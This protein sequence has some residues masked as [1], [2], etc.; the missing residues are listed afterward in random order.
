MTDPATTEITGAT[1][2]NPWDPD[3]DYTY[4]ASDRRHVWNLSMVA[5]MPAWSG[6]AGAIFGDWQIAPIIR[7][8]SGNRSHVT[9]GT[10]VALTGT[11]N[12]RAVQVLDN[13]Y[14]DKTA[15]NYLNPAAFALPAPGTYSTDKPFT[16]VN[17][18]RFQNDVAISRTFKV[19]IGQSVQLRWEIFNVL[20]HVNLDAP[21]TTL[22]SSTFGK[23]LTAGDP[24]IM[25]L[26][27]KYVF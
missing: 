5:R 20:N 8:Q 7:V 12:Q 23:I 26:A 24:R 13:P 4:C 19:G 3:L 1:V 25:Q 2:M 18:G 11:A 22:N 10:D 17:P 27:L 6:V 14:G 15:G 16:I 21:V 9:T